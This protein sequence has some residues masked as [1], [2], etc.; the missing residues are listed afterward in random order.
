MQ[1]ESE[2]FSYAYT[3]RKGFG[4]VWG[5][6]RFW[7]GDI[8]MNKWKI[9]L[10]SLCIT[11]F[12]A[13]YAE[14]V[15]VSAA[16]SLTDVLTVLAQTYEEANPGMRIKI[17]FAGSSTLAKQIENGAPA[18][19]FLSADTAW[20]DYLA[21][22]DLLKNESRKDVLTN[23]LVI[24]APLNSKQLFQW[25]PGINLPDLFTG[26]LCTGELEH[27]PVGKYAKQALDYYGWTTALKSRVVGTEDVR[28]ALAFVARGECAVG[29]VYKTDAHISKAVRV[30]ATLPSESHTPIIYPG[31]LTKKAG[32]DAQ[33]F[34]QFLQSP[35]AAEIFNVY[36]F[37]AIK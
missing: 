14:E 6:R 28:T 34:W 21:A 20:M 10:V 33:Q 16:A 24:I 2:L 7:S 8:L 19:L 30:V 15:K 36:G 26:K 18:E 5:A 23:D 13:A 9:A 31:A 25:S 12:G 17:S 37:I 35:A 22:R 3:R 29:I 4:W 32:A 11:F 27:V 1:S